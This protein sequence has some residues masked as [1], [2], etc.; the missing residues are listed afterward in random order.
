MNRSGPQK[1]NK[2]RQADPAYDK[3]RKSTKFEGL[4]DEVNRTHIFRN[5]LRQVRN[6]YALHEMVNAFKYLVMQAPPINMKMID[7]KNQWI[8][9]QVN[10]SETKEII[11]VLKAFLIIL[12]HRQ[13]CL[14]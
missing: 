12:D 8:E 9:A 1:D 11:V 2:S 13:C 10:K 7:V 14:D 5:V 4:A 6:R 3:F